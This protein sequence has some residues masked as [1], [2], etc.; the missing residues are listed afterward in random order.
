[1][2]R[3]VYSVVALVLPFIIEVDELVEEFLELPAVLVYR[4]YSHYLAHVGSAGRIADLAG[5]AA[6]QEHR[7]VSVLLHVHHGDDRNEVSHMQAVSRR[8]KSDIEF[9]LL[10]SEQLSQS[11]RIGRL[12]YQS[13]FDQYVVHICVLTDIVRNQVFHF[14]SLLVL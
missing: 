5:A 2:A 8:V 6:E 12:F 1:M 10:L 4:I 9:D 14:R 3:A 7:R 13:S 11:L